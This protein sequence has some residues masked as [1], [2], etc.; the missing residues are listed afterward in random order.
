MIC[1][2]C[3]LNKTFPSFLHCFSFIPNDASKV[4]LYI[5]LAPITAQDNYFEVE[6]IDTGMLGCIGKLL[7]IMLR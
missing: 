3:A 6:I 2:E 1:V 4:G 7:F 5:S